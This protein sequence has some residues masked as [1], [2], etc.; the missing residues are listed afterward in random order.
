ML[1]PPAITAAVGIAWMH[2]HQPDPS[3]LRNACCGYPLLERRIVDQPGMAEREAR[4]DGSVGKAVL[5][6]SQRVRK[7]LV[8]PEWFQVGESGGCGLHQDHDGGMRGAVSD[9]PRVCLAVVHIE[10]HQLE[11]RSSGRSM[12]F[13]E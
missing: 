10:T 1:G 3:D 13:D 11:R 7:P 5:G 4:V 12:I 9:F 6:I 2:R 8:P